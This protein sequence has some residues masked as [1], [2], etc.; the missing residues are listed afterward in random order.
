M[1]GW[2]YPFA[3]PFVAIPI[4]LLVLWSLRNPKPQNEQNLKEY[5]GSVWE[6]IKSKRVIG[7]FA[8][9]LVIFVILFGPLITYLPILMYSSFG[10]RP[11]VTGAVIASASVTIALVNIDSFVPSCHDQT[12]NL[13]TVE[14]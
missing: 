5:V 10:A 13:G 1:F 12:R 14:S 6:H 7:L 4:A 9:T 3:L 8:N 11:L 2:H